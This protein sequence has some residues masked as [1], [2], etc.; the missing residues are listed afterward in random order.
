MYINPSEFE[1]III[2]H[3]VRMAPLH[4]FWLWRIILYRI[5]IEQSGK[6]NFGKIKDIIEIIVRIGYYWDI[7]ALF[8]W[9]SDGYTTDPP[10]TTLSEIYTQ[11]PTTITKDYLKL[12]YTS[13][14]YCIVTEFKC[15]SKVLHW[16]IIENV[17]V[18]YNTV[19]VSRTDKTRL[20][21]IIIMTNRGVGTSRHKNVAAVFSVIRKVHNI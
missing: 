7:K 20:D 19:I 8:E 16:I 14:L 5:V 12:W 21:W 9:M 17:P 4:R 6:R 3:H 2:T 10:P 15:P 18:Q 13:W 1:Q 11:V